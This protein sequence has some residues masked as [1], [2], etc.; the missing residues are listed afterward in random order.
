[1]KKYLCSIELEDP[2][3][4]MINTLVTLHTRLITET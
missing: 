2:A 4:I 3:H 1:M